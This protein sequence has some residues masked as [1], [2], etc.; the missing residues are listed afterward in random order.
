MQ[1]NIVSWRKRCRI[2]PAS[3]GK[4]VRPLALEDI[5]SLGNRDLAR[6][7]N[8]GEA[9]PSQGLTCLTRNEINVS[10]LFGSLNLGVE[11]RH[12][13]LQPSVVLDRD[14]RLACWR[15]GWG[16]RGAGLLL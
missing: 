16:N 10:E 14:F 12:E 15:S 2:L 8:H 7:E 11:S 5:G 6:Q 9:R 1:A 13:R 3:Y 4:A